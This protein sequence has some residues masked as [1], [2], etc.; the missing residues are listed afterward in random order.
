[1]AASHRRRLAGHL[2]GDVDDHV[3][4]TTDEPQFAAS[5]QDVMGRNTI[6]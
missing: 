5:A 3:F 1:L 6:T 2:D 4:L